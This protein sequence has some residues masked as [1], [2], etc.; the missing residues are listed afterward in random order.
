MKNQLKE[1]RNSLTLLVLWPLV[2]LVALGLLAGCAS[3]PP[4]P[5]AEMTPIEATV[6]PATVPVTDTGEEA[7]NVEE[8][9]AAVVE[10][11]DV[12]ILESFPVQVQAAVT[13]YLPDGCTTISAIDVV[14]EGNTFRIAITTQR[15]A[16]AM[17]TMAVVP[18]EE[19]VPLETAN[20]PAGD[21][22][23]V[24]N[25]I[26]ASFTLPEG[27]TLPEG[28]AAPVVVSTTEFVQAQVD[29]P[30]FDAPNAGAREI[31]MVAGGQT[32]RVTG[33][34]PDGAWWRV[35]CPDDTVGECWVSAAPDMTAPA[36]LP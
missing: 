33:A 9:N 23:V 28:G 35:I 31:G 15:P 19:I 2:L 26:T 13:G 25:E 32:A 4:E 8:A 21:Y 17:C 27:S 29:V 22:E 24:V 10:R 20:L 3:P 1:S 30:V 14:T 6:P 18:F 5:V 34:S 7:P 16:D 12:R 36:T 11:V